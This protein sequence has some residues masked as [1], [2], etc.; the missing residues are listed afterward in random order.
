MNTDRLEAFANLQMEDGW[1]RKGWECAGR[2]RLVGTAATERDKA[3][4]QERP[5]ITPSLSCPMAL[6]ASSD[7]L[8]EQAAQ[9][10]LCTC[11]QRLFCTAVGLPT[12]AHVGNSPVH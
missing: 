11:H 9:Y 2:C 10:T 12:D 4:M 8:G 6:P 3:A 5:P 7:I 1:S